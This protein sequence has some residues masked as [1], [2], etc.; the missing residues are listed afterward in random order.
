MNIRPIIATIASAVLLAFAAPA[1]AYE[2]TPKKTAQ[3][4]QCV[5]E[6]KELRGEEREKALA[7]C[8]KEHGNGHSQQ[9]KMK[10]CNVEAKAKDLHGDERRAFMSTCL[11]G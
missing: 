9:N 3:L 7:D 5:K 1:A 10:T 8:Q 2:E 11:K 6:A 4:D